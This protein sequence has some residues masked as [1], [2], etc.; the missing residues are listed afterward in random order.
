M[1]NCTVQNNA[2]KLYH[3]VTFIVLS[4]TYKAL[5]LF[6]MTNF[7]E[8]S[9]HNEKYIQ[10]AITDDI[11]TKVYVEKKEQSNRQLHIF[12]NETKRQNENSMLV[13][14]ARKLPELAQKELK[15]YWQP[16]CQPL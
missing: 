1:I 16:L 13:N 10:S 3:R 11:A 15:A 4:F 7:P 14:I 8:L 12:F 6:S 9:I 5:V 2:I